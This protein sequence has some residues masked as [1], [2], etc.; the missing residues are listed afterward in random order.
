[1]ILSDAGRIQAPRISAYD[2]SGLSLYD[3]GDNLGIFIKDG[4][5][6]GIG[7]ATPGYLLDVNGTAGITG[8]ATL[9]DTVR[10]A[11]NKKLQARRS[12]DAYQDVL[13]MDANDN[14]FLNALSTD[15]IIFSIDS[16]AKVVLT[17]TGLL[18][19]RTSSPDSTLHVVADAVGR[20]ALTAQ[21]H[22]DGAEVDIFQVRPGTGSPHLVVDYQGK[23]GIGASPTALLDINS[24]ILRLRTAKTPASAGAA[25]NAG[26]ICWDAD[27]IYVCTATNTW[28]RAAIATW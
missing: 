22:A 19:V 26:D 18:G 28:E 7:T 25:G 8:I 4:G 12:S 27:Y 14:V 17:G 11:N 15:N 10:I 24:D 6:V 2:S 21:A 13:W 1:M 20:T 23:V 9:A 16:N 3:D 5:N